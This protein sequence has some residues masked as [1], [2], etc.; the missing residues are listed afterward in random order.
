MKN[1]LSWAVVLLG[2]SWA[3]FLMYKDSQLSKE[4]HVL[5]CNGVAKLVAMGP[6]KFDQTGA[7]VTR[8]NQVYVP[9]RGE[10]CQ[11]FN[12]GEQQ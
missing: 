5:G 11:S 8:D 12:Y 9:L 10:V 2:I 6:I 3:S 1:K 4:V 7:F